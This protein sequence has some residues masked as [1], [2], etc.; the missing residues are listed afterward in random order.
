MKSLRFLAAALL[1]LSPVTAAEVYFDTVN[2]ASASRLH[3]A[4]MGAFGGAANVTNTVTSSRLRGFNVDGNGT[5]WMAGVEFGYKW[6]TPV[7]INIA[8]EL[9]LYYMNQNI[10]GSKGSA[11]YRSALTYLGAMA[12][13]ILQ[14]DMEALIGEDAGWVGRLKPYIGAGLGYGYGNQK[15]IAYRAP[16]KR[17][18]RDLE[19]GGEPS[20]GYQLFAGVE[21]E[22]ADN[23]SVFGE[24]R[25]MDLYDFGNGDIR[26]ADVSVWMIGV[27]V[28][29]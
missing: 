12:N 1:G 20:F 24:Y 4:Y 7:G 27:R 22:L 19:D 21:V 28:Q 23:F 6:V 29:Y 14:F 5:G 9:E 11:S 25:Y 15:H 2:T 13:G 8:T 18:E 16:G 26:A 3:G 17:R 10:S